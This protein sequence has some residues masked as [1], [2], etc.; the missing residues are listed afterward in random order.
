ME[1]RFS[2][3][4]IEGTRLVINMVH[5]I[6][7]NKCSW[8]KMRLEHFENI[9]RRGIKIGIQVYNQDVMWRQRIGGKGLVKPAF[10]K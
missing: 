2:D 4:F 7:V 8:L 3:K 10:K 9:Y 6:K 1:S 5:F